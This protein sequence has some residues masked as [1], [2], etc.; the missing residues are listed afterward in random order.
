[1]YLFQFSHLISRLEID[2]SYTESSEDIM[3]VL[4]EINNDSILRDKI[5]IHIKE[6]VNQN[7]YDI[8]LK[9]QHCPKC[10]KNNPDVSLDLLENFIRL[11]TSNKV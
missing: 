5:L 9:G 6:F 8:I 10:N 4:K 1:M 11:Y 2:D 7:V 3:G